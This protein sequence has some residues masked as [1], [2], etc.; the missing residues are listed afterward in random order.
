M[1][2][3]SRPSGRQRARRTDSSA[4]RTRSRDTGAA[5]IADATALFCEKGFNGTSITDLADAL[6]VA[7]ASVYYHV[8][9]KQE[10]LLRVLEAG[11]EGFLPRLEE[12]VASDRP[13]REKL[14]LAIENHL[15]FVFNRRDAVAVFLRERRFLEP[16][17]S[18]EYEDLVDR[19]DELFAKILDDGVKAGD[20]TAVNVP[21]ATRLILGMINWIVEWYH[22]DGQ[23]SQAK[24]SETVIELVVDRMLAPSPPR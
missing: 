7:N 9:S 6:G 8:S 16:P 24:L 4:P 12:I 19:Y 5:L 1:L 20:F 23:L 11:M 22:E 18:A 10:L 17:F 2:E 13:G 14:V 3:R 21:V 15:E